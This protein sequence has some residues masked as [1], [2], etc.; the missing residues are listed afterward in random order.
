[1]AGKMRTE[2]IAASRRRRHMFI[3]AARIPFLALITYC[4][5]WAVTWI[6]RTT[7]SQILLP[8]ASSADKFIVMNG[9]GYWPLNSILSYISKGIVPEVKM[10]VDDEL[11]TAYIYPVLL[12][13]PL[14]LSAFK[15]YM[16][17]CH[18]YGNIIMEN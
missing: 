1:M 14:L 4:A 12:F 16:K 10:K 17:T 2:L 5:V 18:S 15:Q 9:L 13:M 8:K 3:M 7:T 6:L 11:I